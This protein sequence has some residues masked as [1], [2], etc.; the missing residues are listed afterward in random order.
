[1]TDDPKPDA[2]QQLAESAAAKLTE[3]ANPREVSEL[4]RMIAA[5]ERVAL[6]VGRLVGAA[7]SAWAA[8]P[9]K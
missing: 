7:L 1:M 9:G 6:R 4:A 2:L 8:R 3:G 5:D